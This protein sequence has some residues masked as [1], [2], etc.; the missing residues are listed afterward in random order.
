MPHDREDDWLQD[1]P[2]IRDRL[3][4]LFYR[5]L[6]GPPHAV[7]DFCQEVLARFLARHR[8]GPIRDWR[9]YIYRIALNLCGELNGERRQAAHVPM[10]TVE[11]EVHADSNVWETYSGCPTSGEILDD[12]AVG[13]PQYLQPVFTLRLQGLTVMQI[14]ART[15]LPRATVQT[16]L[17]R[18]IHFIAER[19]AQEAM[20]D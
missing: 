15:G 13:L 16:Y 17:T 19:S 5:I 11:S 7:E 20:R 12:L 14:A 4:A 18:V 8:R 9:T 6:R 3:R 2:L 1:Y 10:E